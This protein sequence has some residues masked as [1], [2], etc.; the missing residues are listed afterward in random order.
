MHSTS[1]S[2]RLRLVEQLWVLFVF[3]LVCSFFLFLPSPLCTYLRNDSLY[4][5]LAQ[6]QPLTPAITPADT[7]FATTSVFMGGFFFKHLYRSFDSPVLEGKHLNMESLGANRT[8]L[9]F[10]TA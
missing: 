8:P 3:F 2:F 9:F 6:A 7:A 10:I 4:I 1:E 5:V